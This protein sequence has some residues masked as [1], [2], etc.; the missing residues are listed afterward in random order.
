MNVVTHFRELLSH[1]EKTLIKEAEQGSEANLWR[2]NGQRSVIRAE[3][4]RDL[5]TGAKPVKGAIRM[6]GGQVLGHLNLSGADLVHELHFTD[7]AFEDTVSLQQARAEHPVEWVGGCTAAINA[8]EFESAADLTIQG[9]TVTGSISLHWANIR[10]DLRMSGSRL[11]PSNGQALNGA[12]L[13]VD[14]TLFLDGLDGKHFHAKGEVC[15]RS[16][17]IHGQLDC[18]HAHLT[19]PSGYCINAPY[20]ELGGE[21]LCDQGFHAK[22]EVCLERAQ[23]Q[24]VRAT[25]GRFTSSTQYALHLDALQARGG[26][27]LDRGFRATAT[28]RLVG[29]NITGEL[30]CTGGT[31]E[32]PSGRA[33][34]AEHVNVDDVYLDRGFTAHGEVRFPGAQV[35]HQFNAKNGVFD[36]G[37]GT[38]LDITGLVC[39]GD[40]LL[41]GDGSGGFRATGQILMRNAEITRDLDF[42]GGKLHGVKGLE[43]SGMRVGGCLI[44]ILDQPPGGHVDLTGAQISRL[45]DTKESWPPGRYTLAGLTLQST[46]DSQSTPHSHKGHKKVAQRIA[47]LHETKGYSPDAY[48]QLAQVYRLD[49]RGSDAEE[50]LIASQRDLRERGHLPRRS[51]AWNWF[52]DISVG[53]GYRLYRP[54]LAVLFLGLLGWLFYALAQRANLIWA[55]GLTD[56]SA[57]SARWVC[58]RG[59]PC[60]YPA[61]YSFQLLIPGLDL[62]EASQWLPDAAMKPWGLL[63]MIYTWLMIIFGWI[64]ATAVLAGVSRI[65]RQR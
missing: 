62:R 54:F 15:L 37:H 8:D 3:L 24:H 45:K 49:G 4:L 10:G 39:G 11:T 38:A 53:Y 28:V 26:V 19:N 2:E 59:Y 18:R 50:V 58:P 36:N 5:C 20:L 1:P 33:L 51:K 35:Q 9:V 17:H 16:A 7:C 31:F 14:G 22:G 25:G 29:A 12:D 64:L 43:A 41:N 42:T 30:N 48:Q 21:L 46:A 44:W 13:R 60:F 32:N 34:D 40:V 27:Y 65:F 56:K 55:T 47:W 61:P 63:M 57:Q 52:I 23:V 6:K